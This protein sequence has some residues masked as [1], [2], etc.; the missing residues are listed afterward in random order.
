M[1]VKDDLMIEVRKIFRE[2]WNV[3]GGQKVPDVR[4]I[5]LGNEAVEIEGTVL[6][7]DLADST[8]LVDGYG[9]KFAAEVYKTYLLIAAM[10]IKNEG[11]V[12]TAY[13]G[14]R[15]M[16]VFFDGR[17]NTNAVRCALKIKWAVA[18]IVNPLLRAQYLG[19]SYT[20]R[21]V[22]GIDTSTLRAA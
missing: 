16:A 17:K 1:S 3:R 7:A 18:N 14:D 22:V 13:D 9:W 6:Y 15:V 4:D 5:Q 21:Q 11:G 12:I 10:L 8:K 20:V 2:Q 19:T